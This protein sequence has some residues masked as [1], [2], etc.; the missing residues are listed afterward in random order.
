M[1]DE[2]SCLRYACQ[3]ASLHSDDMWTQ[4]G[5]VFVSDGRVVAAA[6]KL[7]DGVRRLPGRLQ[8]RETKYRF[9]EHAERGVIYKA[10]RLGIATDGGRLYCPW[11]ACTDCARAIICAGVREV[12]GLISLRVATPDRW[13]A[14][15]SLAERMLSESGVSMRWLAGEIGE[16]VLFDGRILKC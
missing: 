9:I 8:E 5:A 4:V 11:F 16:T 2:E 1:I 3:Y 12:V 13:E 7:P 14:D 10:A 15:V 6:N